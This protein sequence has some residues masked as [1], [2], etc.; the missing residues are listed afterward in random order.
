M[1]LPWRI[2]CQEQEGS[3]SASQVSEANV[4]GNTDTSLERTSNVVTIP[5]DSH[6][7]EW[8]DSRGDQESTSVLNSWF[9]GGRKHN[10][11]NDSHN[12]E[13][14]HKDTSLLHL[15]SCV[16]RANGEKASNWNY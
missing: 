11:A 12:F 14:E 1:S 2:L 10:K 5:C 7:Y 9:A 16:S 3:D 4:H 15:I 6:W 13:S 8:V